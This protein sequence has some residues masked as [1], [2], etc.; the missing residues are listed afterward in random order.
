MYLLNVDLNVKP[1]SESSL[2]KIFRAVFIPAISMQ[3]GFE[4]A[5]LLR[6]TVSGSDYRLVIG[7][8]SQPLQQ[9]WVAAPLHQEVW[10]QMESHFNSYN[11]LTY[12]LVD[13]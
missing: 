9:K 4:R 12:S 2:E 13:G 10:P 1:G 8:A 11:V 7:F 6:S 5:A 3:E